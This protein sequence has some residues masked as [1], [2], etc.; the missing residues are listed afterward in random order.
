MNFNNKISCVGYGN[1]FY[2]K[3]GD[4]LQLLHIQVERMPV[5]NEYTSVIFIEC[6]EII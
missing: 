6:T 5:E 1:L 2:F 3:D 4:I